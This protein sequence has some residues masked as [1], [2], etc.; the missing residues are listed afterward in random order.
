LWDPEI[1]A[2]LENGQEFR[3]RNAVVYTR[4]PILTDWAKWVLSVIDRD[5]T[6]VS[7]L[8]KTWIKH[9]G[10]ALIGRIALRVPRWDLW[11]DNPEGRTAITHLVDTRD[12]SAHRLLHVGDRTFIETARTEGRDSLPQ[13]TSYIMSECRARLWEAM[14]TAGLDNLA[15]V[16]TDSMIVNKRGLAALRKSWTEHEASLWAVKGTW[17][18]ME[19]YG[20]RAYRA[21]RTRR[22]S[23]VP[24]KA[25]ET[26]P[27]RFEGERWSGVAQDIERGNPQAVTITPW[28][29]K[30]T[31]RDPRRI[32]RPGVP[33]HT[34]ALSVD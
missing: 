30:L 28:V 3:I 7:P 2:L 5:N 13:V 19:L 20:P 16:D 12:D 24:R 22:I 21:G 31:A 25:L 32:D 9:S 33:G 34:D 17:Q 1:D 27:N 8:V 26:A 11:G 23:G 6:D 14:S 4:Q 10:R 15:H 29:W 18:T